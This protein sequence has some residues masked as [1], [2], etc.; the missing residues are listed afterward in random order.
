VLGLII[1]L[2]VGGLI[3]VVGL[4]I[5]SIAGLMRSR[6]GK[7]KKEQWEMEETLELHRA[8]YVGMGFG[9]DDGELPP[10]TI[11]SRGT[12]LNGKG[13]AEAVGFIPADSADRED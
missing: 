2:A 4:S 13:K 12:T 6:K 1:I 9:I 5:D 3:I 11:F 8:A 10:S 7:Y